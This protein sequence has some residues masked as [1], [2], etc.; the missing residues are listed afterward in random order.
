MSPSAVKSFT[1]ILE[2]LQTG[3]GW[4]VA[5]IPFDVAKTWPVRRGN[6][7]RGEIAGFV[8]RSSLMAYGSSGGYFLLVNKKMQAA[9]KAVAG[10]RVRIRLEPDLEERVAVIPEELARALKEDK[11]LRRW[12]DG[13]GDGA[14]EWRVAREASRAD[15][16]VA[17]ANAGGRDRSAAHSEGGLPA[18]AA[19]ASWM[20]PNDT[21]EAAQS[22]LGNLSFADR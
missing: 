3:L 9:A 8:F 4:V 12:F 22:S 16:R 18:P 7:V 20:G 11:R 19:G 21:G 13:M 17:A 10:S 5:R 15:G 2:P 14:Q 1:A 6:R